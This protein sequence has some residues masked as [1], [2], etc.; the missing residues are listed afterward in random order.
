MEEELT[1]LKSY[2]SLLGK[3]SDE[4]LRL[5]F[6][7]NIF[8]LSRRKPYSY[9]SWALDPLHPVGNHHSKTFCDANRGFF[10]H[11]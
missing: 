6:G 2:S 4:S 5:S 10:V 3:V 7:S 1:F 8:H 11:S 9:L